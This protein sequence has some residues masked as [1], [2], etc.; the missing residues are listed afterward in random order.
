M[1]K[2]GLPLHHFSPPTRVAIPFEIG[3]IEAKP[4]IAQSAAPHRHTFYEIIF[5]ADGEGSHIIDFEPYPVAPETIYFITPGQVH[6]W[7]LSRPLAGYV[8]L[9]D[10]EFLPAIAY[11]PVALRNLDFFHRFDH[12]PM[13]LLPPEQAQPFHELCKHMMAEYQENAFG[14]VTVLQSSLRIFLVH[15]QRRYVGQNG[16]F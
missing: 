14:C 8:M 10:E 9:F 16:K 15:A 7:Q 11:E 2:S 1:D 5:V 13:L 3:R 4:A 6:S 12:S